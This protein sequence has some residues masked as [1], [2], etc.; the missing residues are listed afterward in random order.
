MYG[1]GLNDRLVYFSLSM[2][3]IFKKEFIIEEKI[4]PLKCV[5]RYCSTRTQAVWPTLSFSG[6]RVK[7][8]IIL[9]VYKM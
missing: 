8:R 5:D 9:L 3:C 7:V 4:I 2:Y 6:K 1:C